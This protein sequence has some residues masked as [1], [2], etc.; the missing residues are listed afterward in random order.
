MALSSCLGR[1][2]DVIRAQTA[3]DRARVVSLVGVGGVGKT[4]L[5]LQVAAESSTRYPHGV[6]FCDL[7]PVADPQAVPFVVA[8]ALALP[9]RPSAYP[10][11]SIAGALAHR[12]ALV[13]MDNCEHLVDEVASLVELV[14]SRCADVRVLATSRE[15]WPSTASW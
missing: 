7:A 13:V 15:A 3:L 11:E 6:W 12:R 9:H 2:D 10:A 14:A 1:A 4:R 5:A 8:T